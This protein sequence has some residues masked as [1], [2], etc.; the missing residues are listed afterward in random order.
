MLPA[1]V[2]VRWVREVEAGFNARFS[3]LQ[4]HYRYLIYNSPVA[5]A[6]FNTKLTHQPRPLSD[7]LMAEAGKALLG[8]HDFTSYRASA[9]QAHSPV[10]TISN[11]RVFRRDDLVGVE[12]SADGFLHHMVRNIV[13]VLMAIGVG[14]RSVTWAAEVLAEKNRAL[15]GVTA[16]PNGLYLVGVDYPGWQAQSVSALP[17]DGVLGRKT[18]AN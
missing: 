15:G 7:D 6:L 9:C 14:D 2:R 13:G 10:R 5:S 1:D 16:P 18:G 3:A 12:V 8:T 4:R 17:F 11:L